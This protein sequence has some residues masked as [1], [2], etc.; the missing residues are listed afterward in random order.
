LFIVAQ[1]VVG[2]SEV[3]LFQGWILTLVLMRGI[4]AQKQS[5]PRAYA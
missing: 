3:T 2:L 5:I 1:V 4:L